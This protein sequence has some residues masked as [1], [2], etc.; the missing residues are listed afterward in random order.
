MGMMQTSVRAVRRFYIDIHRLA[1]KNRKNKTEESYHIYTIDGEMFGKARTLMDITAKEGDELYV[2][3][4]PIE[5]TD[6][7]IEMLRRGVRVF[8]L[9]RPTLIARKRKELGLSKTSRNDLRAMMTLEPKW[10]IEVG[11]DFLVIRRLAATFRSLLK[12]HVSLLNRAKALQEAERKILID[13]VKSLEK[14]MS[15]MAMLI[16]AEAEKRMPAYRKVVEAL[17]ISGDNY[18]FAK[19]ALAEI[20]PYIDRS[21]SCRRIMKLLGLYRGHRGVDKFYNKPARSALSRLT[22]ALLNNTYHRAKD[23]EKILRRIW[24]TIKQSEPQERLGA[25][26]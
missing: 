14:S 2:D 15:D 12:T 19:E 8:Y 22:A 11:E 24:T 18:L 3:T 16:V 21:T 5:L 7:F 13:S 26:A 10:F 9:R 25:P 6:E 23:E 20:M 1:N 4:I 17:G